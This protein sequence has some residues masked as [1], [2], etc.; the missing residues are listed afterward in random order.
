VLTPPCVC[1]VNFLVRHTDDYMVVSTGNFA[2]RHSH[3]HFRVASHVGRERGASL[4]GVRREPGHASDD[5]G[6]DDTLPLGQQ[7]SVRSRLADLD[8]P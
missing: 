2:V 8:E 7:A 3:G 6:V 1:G 4:L 5:E